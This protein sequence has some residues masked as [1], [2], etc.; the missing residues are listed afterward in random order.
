MLF[1]RR[2]HL[3]WITNS[4]FS[5]PGE[6]ASHP[7]W[8]TANIEL[9]AR[10]KRA[11]E[12]ERFIFLRYNYSQSYVYY[13]KSR[14]IFRRKFLLSWNWSDRII[15]HSISRR[16]FIPCYAQSWKSRSL[17]PLKCWRLH[18]VHFPKCYCPFSC[19]VGWPVTEQK[20]AKFPLSLISHPFFSIPNLWRA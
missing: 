6:L 1:I 11:L 19:W 7:V 13:A 18:N 17:Y 3:W 16:Q 5:E 14:D 9:G 8:N 15:S 10:T 12:N 2:N 20:L 4:A